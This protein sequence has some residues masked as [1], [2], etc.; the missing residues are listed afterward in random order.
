MKDTCVT[1]NSRFYIRTHPPGLGF[2]STCLRCKR[3]IESGYDKM[4]FDACRPAFLAK[5]GLMGIAY[6]V[7]YALAVFY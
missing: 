1:A 6:H 3:K 7:I 5:L 2:N 4:M